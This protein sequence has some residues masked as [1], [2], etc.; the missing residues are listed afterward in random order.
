MQRLKENASHALTESHASDTLTE[1]LILA[2]TVMLISGYYGPQVWMTPISNFVDLPRPLNQLNTYT[3]RDF[4]VP[5]ILLAFFVAHLPSC[6]IN[7]ARARRAQ[8]LPLAPV[9]LD[10]IPMIVYTTAVG[11]WIF[12]P[13]SIILR[14]NH[15]LL[16]CLTQSFVFGRM[17]TKIILA[18]LTRQ[19][20]PYWTVLMAPLIAGAFGT[21]LYRV[22][23]PGF[24]E[25][26]ELYWLYAYFVFA[27]VVYFR[28][29]F[30][31]INSICNYLGINCLTI[32]SK[33]D[34]REVAN[35]KANGKAH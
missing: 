12:S 18:H 11:A 21:N 22:G 1:G 32:P 13:S 17:T 3:A 8:N 27:I 4:W 16:F 19:P 24:S 34:K 5:I 28:W 35:G 29:A 23:L 7:V 30:L 15:L 9:F 31:V 20:F 33:K 14:H 25:Q 10:W 26:A 6:I 2:C